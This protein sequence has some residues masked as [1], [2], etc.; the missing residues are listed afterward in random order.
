MGKMMTVLV[1]ATP[2][3]VPLRAGQGATHKAK[4]SDHAA[5]ADVPGG[6]SLSELAFNGFLQSFSSG[7]SESA[8]AAPAP[9]PPAQAPAVQPRDSIDFDHSDPDSVAAPA[10]SPRSRPDAQTSRP[11]EDAR[12]ANSA[13]IRHSPDT[14]PPARPPHQSARPD[15]AAARPLTAQVTQEAP[16]LISQPASALSARSA[17][18]AQTQA[19]SSTPA[20]GAAGD[21]TTQA[22]GTA[23]QQA[24]L[25]QHPK[26]RSGR[27]GTNSQPSTA[28]LNA[29]AKIV[30]GALTPQAIGATQGLNPSAAGLANAGQNGQS[31]QLARQPI[32]PTTA[33]TVLAG[34][35]GTDFAALRAGGPPPLPRPPVPIPPRLVT[36]QVSV[37]IQK[38][39]GQGVDQIRIQLKP[40][41]LGR[42][43]VKL[44]VAPDGRVNVAVS[45]EN[46]DTLELLQRD[47]RALQNA[48]QDAGLRTDSDSL[49]FTLKGHGRD[50]S[51]GEDASTPDENATLADQQAQPDQP[52]ELADGQTGD[53]RVDIKV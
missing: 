47:A 53:L 46:P 13:E 40:A 51:G 10:V 2:Q 44:N 52:A 33:N 38:A 20:G 22:T 31:G 26:G 19:T 6:V 32:F 41:D 15:A 23:P 42:V 49:Q 28:S 11:V 37:Q 35:S 21:G 43:D 25:H 1:T 24:L 30:P 9:R 5:R 18:A 3:E 7:L 14:A 27:L 12:P 17:V 34:T 39:V 45:V 4:D 29:G 8:H 48:L 50:F 16:I 36:N